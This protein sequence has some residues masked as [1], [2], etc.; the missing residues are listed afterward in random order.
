MINACETM[1]SLVRIK[2]NASDLTV[3]KFAVHGDA[4]HDLQSKFSLYI[5]LKNP[6]VYN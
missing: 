6:E 1:V 4:Q 3:F 2:L 5:H